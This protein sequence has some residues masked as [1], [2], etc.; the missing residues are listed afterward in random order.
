MSEEWLWKKSRAYI[1]KGSKTNNVSHVYGFEFQ[2]PGYCQHYLSDV[3]ITVVST[4]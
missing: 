2:Y 4:A 1:V 3:H